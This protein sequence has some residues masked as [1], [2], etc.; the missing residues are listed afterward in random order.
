MLAKLGLRSM[1]WLVSTKMQTIF[2]RNVDPVLH[3]RR[4]EEEREIKKGM[5]RDRDGGRK[6]AEEGVRKRVGIGEG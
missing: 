1:S 3:G 5:E 6:E 4:R 2:P